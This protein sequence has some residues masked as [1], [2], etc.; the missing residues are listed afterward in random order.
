MYDPADPYAKIR[1]L[2]ELVLMAVLENTLSRTVDVLVAAHPEF[3]VHPRPQGRSALVADRLIGRIW[4]LQEA[5]RRY[6]SC[7][8][9][10]P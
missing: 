2:P 1:A 3:H 10:R 5:L 9:S 7:S 8:R 6:R 4:E